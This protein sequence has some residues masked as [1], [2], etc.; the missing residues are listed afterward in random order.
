MVQLRLLSDPKN[1]ERHETH[2][3]HDESGS[4]RDEAMPQVM[5]VVN[6]F[7]SGDAQVEDEKRHGKGENAVAQCGQ[8][9]DALPGNLV[10]RSHGKQAV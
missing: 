2:Q 3:V 5:F 7:E 4:E 8:A 1:A 9:L 6:G 10:I